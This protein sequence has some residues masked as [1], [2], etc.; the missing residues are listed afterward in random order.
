M[1]RMKT[2]TIA[3]ASAF[4]AGASAMA[5]PSSSGNAPAVEP[6]SAQPANDTQ[7]LVDNATSAVR[8][9]R[10]NQ[11]LDRLLREAKGVFIVPRYVKGA[12]VVG[13]EG[14]QGVLLAHK[15]GGWSDPA[16]MSVASGS[17]GAQVGGEAGPVVMLL[18]TPKAI[19]EFT[20]NG[21]FSL[22]ANAGLTIV[23]YSARGQSNV[24]KGDVIVWTNMSGAYVGVNVSGTN[25]TPNQ[26]ENGQYYGRSVST[27][28][29]INGAVRNASA[30][31]LRDAL[32]A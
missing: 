27:Q 2:A 9:L 8:Q 16:F 13:G 11:Q 22:N 31:K 12:A 21:N 25:I 30:A 32:P 7:T 1:T 23:N 20:R 28:Q 29:I 4:L 24:G 15:N 6:M 14:G 17:V 19:D 10:S 26:A 18:M 3:L 5:A